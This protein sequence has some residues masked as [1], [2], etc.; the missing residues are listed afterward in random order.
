MTLLWWLAPC[1]ANSSS[2]TEAI[3]WG[4]Q[5]GSGS[6]TR[7]Q[8]LW[9]HTCV[10]GKPVDARGLHGLSCRKSAPRRQRHSHMND[11]IRRAIKRAQVPAVKELV[12]LT[13]EDNKRPDG[14]TLLPWAKGKPLAWDVTVPD[15]YA[16]T[17]RW[18]GVHPRGGS[19]SSGTTQDCQVL[20]AGKHTH[21]LPHCHRN[22][23]HMGWHVYWAS[24]GDWQTHHSHHSG[25]QRNSFSVSAPVHSSAAG[26]C[27]LLPQ[28]NE[29][30]IRSRR[31]R[32]FCLVFTPAALC[33]W[34]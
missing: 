30:R 5:G 18:H 7:L 13:L 6:T 14:T 3:G 8:S 16:V 17:H 27:G 1:T 29:H 23:R 24:P 33:W 12:S 10:C 32:C 25:H 19:S 21:V 2:R 11:I 9:P 15:T 26:E 22:S 28:H 20:Q 31:S 4:H 34:A